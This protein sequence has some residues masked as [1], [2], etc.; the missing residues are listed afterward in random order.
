MDSEAAG[1]TGTSRE[2]ETWAFVTLAVL[3]FPILSVI[4]VGGIGFIV[5]MQHLLFGPPTG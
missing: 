2:D 5:W 3:L 1:S 4:V